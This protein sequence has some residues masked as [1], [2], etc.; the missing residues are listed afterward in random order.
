MSRPL[1]LTF[2]DAHILAQVFGLEVV[3][4]SL[5]ATVD[6]G[7]TGIIFLIIPPA[8]KISQAGT[9]FF[10]QTAYICREIPELRT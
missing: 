8:T 6:E 10:R 3:V 9:R 2:F 7:G 5:A 1:G 4:V